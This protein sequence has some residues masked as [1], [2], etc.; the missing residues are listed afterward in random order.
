MT[1][2]EVIEL[3]IKRFFQVIII[4]VLIIVGLLYL[5]L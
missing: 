2:N 1:D 3:M 4:L 5:W